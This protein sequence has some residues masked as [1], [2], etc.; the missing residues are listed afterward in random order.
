MDTPLFFKNNNYNLFG[1]LYQPDADT[2]SIS[3]NYCSHKDLGIV[4]CSP[5]AEEKLLSHRV[6]VNLA[7]ALTE[8]GIYCLRFDYMG[9]GDS[10]GNFEDA[11]IETRISDI[12]QAVA[13]LKKRT[14]IKKVGLLGVRLGAT[15]TCLTNSDINHA[16]FSILI[17]PITDGNSYIEQCLRSNLTT[18]LAVFK[19]ITKDRKKLI[20]DLLLGLHVNIDGY[21]LTNA[22]YQEIRYI[23]LLINHISVPSHILVIQVSRNVNQ[24]VNPNL[25]EFCTKVKSLSKQADLYNVKDPYFWTDTKIYI[26]HSKNILGIITN[27]L[28]QISL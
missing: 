5:F 4:L 14:N 23:N 26:P 7:R 9:H 10:S 27:W 6:M 19:K 22:V 2:S 25:N 8:L 12:K 11:T 13:Y 16:D 20:S 15:L 3:S 1:V 18:Q 21:L 17:S 28:N 24:P